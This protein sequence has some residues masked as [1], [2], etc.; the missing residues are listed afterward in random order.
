M[1]EKL[2]DWTGRNAKILIAGLS[3]LVAANV[4]IQAYTHKTTP[5]LAWKGGGFGMY[6]EPHAEDRSVWLTF[7]GAEETA[8]VRLWPETPEFA[9]WQAKAGLRGTAFLS[10]IRYSAER[11]RYFPRSGQADELVSLAARVKWPENLV[12]ELKPAEGKVF[13]R[14]DITLT[15][16]ENRYDV[17]AQ[18][19]IRTPVF[20]YNGEG[21]S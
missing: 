1:F 18:K 2:F 17:K 20:E 9:A 4:L 19:V 14:N 13:K 15:V 8:T 10:S 21:Q 11:V 3:I 16:F 5:L 12:G 7:R 6:T